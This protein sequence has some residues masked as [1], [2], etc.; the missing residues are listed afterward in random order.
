M[1]LPAPSPSEKRREIESEAYKKMQS[2]NEEYRRDKFIKDK[3]LSIEN[4]QLAE[5]RYDYMKTNLLKK[6]PNQ[7]TNL[8]KNLSSTNLTATSQNKPKI[9]QKVTRS[10]TIQAN[11]S[12]FKGKVKSSKGKTEESEIKMMPVTSQHGIKPS[13]RVDVIGTEQNDTVEIEKEL[14]KFHSM[15]NVAQLKPT[16]PVDY[17]WV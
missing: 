15:Q 2:A 9:P 7:N 11:S 3:R 14:N 12:M 17:S 4:K 10:S 1:Q 6:V 8:S 13:K 5:H 16:K